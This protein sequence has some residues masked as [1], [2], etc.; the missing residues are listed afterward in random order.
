MNVE[1]QLNIMNNNLQHTVS[2]FLNVSSKC[3]LTTEVPVVVNFLSQVIFVSFVFEYGYVCYWSWK[4]GK[5]KI[6]WDKN[7]TTDN[8]YIFFV[9]LFCIAQTFCNRLFMSYPEAFKRKGSFQW[10][11]HLK[12]QQQIQHSFTN[13]SYRFYLVHYTECYMPRWLHFLDEI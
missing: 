8:I 3:S 12:T 13:I 6:T 9:F 5:I 11:A 2:M 4:K 1:R 7:L 10:L